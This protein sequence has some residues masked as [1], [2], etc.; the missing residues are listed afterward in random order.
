MD[1]RTEIKAK[2]NLDNGVKTVESSKQ[3]SWLLGA[4]SLLFMVALLSLTFP[5]MFFE[6]MPFWYRVA[7]QTL[8]I[9]GFLASVFGAK[10][11]RI[12]GWAGIGMF[13]VY[14]GI[15]SIPSLDH[16]AFDANGDQSPS[17]WIPKLALWLILSAALAV[18]YRKLSI[19]R[20]PS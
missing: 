1:T 12:V 10:Y 15:G 11:L 7:D 19:K 8:L 16:P 17:L 13:I 14:V 4:S 5:R 6:P 9:A 18:C 20:P 3:R 2:T